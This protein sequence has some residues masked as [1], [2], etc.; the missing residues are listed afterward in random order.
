MNVLGGAICMKAHFE[1]RRA[2]LEDP[3]SVF[4]LLRCASLTMC[5]G[6]MHAR[7]LGHPTA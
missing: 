6:G 2:C 4:L 5:F 1:T 3:D 7:I